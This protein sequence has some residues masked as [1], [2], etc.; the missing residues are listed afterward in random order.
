[1]QFQ[2]ATARAQNVRQS[3]PSARLNAQDSPS[4][5]RTNVHNLDVI[6]AETVKMP[7]S[8]PV[9]NVS[10]R[11]TAPTAH[12]V[13]GLNVVKLVRHAVFPTMAQNVL[14]QD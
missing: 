5:Y 3:K 2:T 9:G 4:R 7:V 8:R 12:D 14:T 6:A 1:M 13:F 10:T 11:W